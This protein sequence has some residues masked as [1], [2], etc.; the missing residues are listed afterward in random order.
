MT[1]IVIIIS[2]TFGLKSTIWFSNPFYPFL[3]DPRN[4]RRPCLYARDTVRR[5]GGG[6]KT[7]SSKTEDNTKEGLHRN[8]GRSTNQHFRT[9]SDHLML[10]INLVDCRGKH[11]QLLSNAVG[12]SAVDACALAFMR[13]LPHKS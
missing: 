13:M 10:P 5:S 9:K 8:S 1:S 2:L 7:C 11:T 3:I 6:R 12:P 4:L